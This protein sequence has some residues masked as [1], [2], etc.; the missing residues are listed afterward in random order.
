MMKRL[1][2]HCS[3]REGAAAFIEYDDSWYDG[4]DMEGR[5]YLCTNCYARQ[6][7]DHAIYLAQQARRELLNE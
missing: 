1:C 6:E 2:R 5:R 7:A 4:Y 3:Y